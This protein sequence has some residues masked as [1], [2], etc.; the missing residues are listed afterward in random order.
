MPFYVK[1]KVFLSVLLLVIKDCYV[2]K[3]IIK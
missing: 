2:F 1:K 3:M